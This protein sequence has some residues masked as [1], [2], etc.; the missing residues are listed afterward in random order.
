MKETTTQLRT[1]EI[2][3]LS[4][5]VLLS[6]FLL[7]TAMG[8]A[9]VKGSGT[10]DYIPVWTGSGTI[11][12]SIMYQT[13]SRIGIGRTTPQYALDVDGHINASGYALGETVV[14]TVPGGANSA[15]L[16]LGILALG[17]NT[18]G[19]Y[20]TA[21]GYYAMP[22]NSTGSYNTATGY[23]ALYDNNGNYNTA[24]G[25]GALSTNSVPTATRATTPP[26]VT[27]RSTI[28]R[29]G[30][31][32]SR[33]APMPAAASPAATATILTSAAQGR[34][35]TA[36]QFALARAGRRHPSSSRG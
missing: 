22:N 9:Q 36:G 4:L 17:S 25:S 34:R 15:N 27:R 8:H 30:P 10:T 12:N 5:L 28:S 6:G 3:V 16:A 2:Q 19:T 18:S 26:S 32:I 13:D 29:R 31:T 35:A 20:N 7:C 21:L 24:D 23:F 33:S 1:A 14:L 11:G